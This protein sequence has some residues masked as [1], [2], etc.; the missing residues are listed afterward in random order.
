MQRA[1]NMFNPFGPGGPISQQG[2]QP[3]VEPQPKPQGTD[4]LSNL[5]SQLESMQRQLDELAKKKD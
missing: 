1:M 5:K 3:G 2:G 4:D